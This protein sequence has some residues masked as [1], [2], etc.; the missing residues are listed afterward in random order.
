[1]HATDLL[2]ANNTVPVKLGAAAIVKTM[3][4]NKRNEV[5]RGNRFSMVLVFSLLSA[6]MTLT[7]QNS[8][9]G[10]KTQFR[11]T[12]ARRMAEDMGLDDKTSKDFKELFGR[13]AEEMEKAKEQHPEAG[14]DNRREQKTLTDAEIDKMIEESI[15]QEKKRVEV[16]EKYFK[17]FRK[18]LTARQ[19]ARVM[20][21]DKRRGDR[22]MDFRGGS[23]G[24]DDNLKRPDWNKMKDRRVRN[25]APDKAED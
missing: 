23:K 1:M 19:T 11:E 4:L 24:G 12:Q 8:K 18:I 13:Y 14:K 22:H 9:D 2:T 20:N 3:K 5:M 6:G 15:D 16:K 21:M 25:G 10:D 17:E 7:A